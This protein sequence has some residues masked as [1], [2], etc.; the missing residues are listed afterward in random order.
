MYYTYSYVT[1][2]RIGVSHQILGS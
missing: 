2:E 1:D